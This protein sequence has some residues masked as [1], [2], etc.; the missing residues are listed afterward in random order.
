M[1]CYTI[2]MIRR[3]I[4]TSLFFCAATFPSVTATEFRA[5][6]LTRPGI[7]TAPLK[8]TFDRA[9]IDEALTK[10]MNPS[11][12]VKITAQNT[13]KSSIKF[14]SIRLFNNDGSPASVERANKNDVLTATPFTFIYNFPL[15]A[16]DT[17]NVAGVAFSFI[18]SGGDDN[19]GNAVVTSVLTTVNF[20]SGNACIAIPDE[21]VLVPTPPPPQIDDIQNRVVVKRVGGGG[22]ATSAGPMSPGT[23][24]DGAED[25]GLI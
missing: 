7:A 24:T 3:V 20:Q 17:K 21:V 13:Q 15:N 14:N 11:I 6:V 9:K 2:S 1:V 4:F 19:T 22:T 12:D 25:A 5:S 23:A 10:G 8:I 16:A 18:D